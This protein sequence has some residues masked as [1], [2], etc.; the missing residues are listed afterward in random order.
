MM[1]HSSLSKEISDAQVY[2]APVCRVISVGTNRVICGS[3][4][5]IVG[6]D[7]GEW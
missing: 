7:E 3:E 1:T 5:E 2:E 4:T 6:E